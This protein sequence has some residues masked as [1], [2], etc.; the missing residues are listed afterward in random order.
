[1]TLHPASGIRHP[2]SIRNIIFDFGG[3]L[4]DLDIDLTKKKFTEFGPPRDGAAIPPEE[5]GK[6]FNLLVEH[7]ET[8][9]IA[10]AEF[11]EAIRDH[12]LKPLSDEAIN[13]AWNALLG[14]IPEH[15]IRLLEKIRGNYRIFLLSNSNEV[16]YD[17]YLKRFTERFGYKDF[18][19]IFEKAWFSFNIGMKKP[20]R[21]I[22]EFVLAQHNIIPQETLFIDDTLM[23]VEGAAATGIRGYHLKPGEDISTL[24]PLRHL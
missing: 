7:L 22:F 18:D 12:Y 19:T 20:D 8:G 11:R 14:D 16:H 5:A 6:A 1:M 23:H 9:R 21:E 4:C 24:F 15:R 17:C 3:V 13:D 2:E 10:P